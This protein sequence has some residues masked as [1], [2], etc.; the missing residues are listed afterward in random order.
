MKH[1]KFF[2]LFVFVAA[3]G[4]GAVGFYFL[5]MAAFQG[6]LTRTGLLPESLFG[7]T[8]PQPLLYEKWMMQSNMREADVLVIGDSFSDARIW[9]TVLTKRGLKVRTESWDNMRGV[10]ADFMPWLRAQGFSGKYIVLES[11]ERNMAGDLNQSVACQHMQYH[12]NI[13]TDTPRYPPITSFDVNSRNYS[14]K[15]SIGL[16]TRLNVWRY[17]RLSQSPYFNTWLLPNDVKMARIADGCE[18]FSHARCE[19]ALFLAYDKAD[20]IDGSVLKNM[21]VLSTRL[22]GVTPIWVFVPNKSTAYLYPDKK[23]WGE[24]E[25]RFRAPN[26]LQ[27]TQQ[28]LSEKIVDLYPGNNT[29]FSTTGYIKMGE[30]V[31]GSMSSIKK[32]N[33]YRLKR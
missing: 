6:D 15:L 32:E 2:S 16:R 25:R 17:E 8:R 10:C 24:A 11:I 14:G 13:K 4:Y 18:L 7:W 1:A 27:M 20:A 12:P 19:D 30:L 5:P 3:M 9:Q 22:N 23:F 26:L 33:E 29:H 31:Y 21:A 28:A